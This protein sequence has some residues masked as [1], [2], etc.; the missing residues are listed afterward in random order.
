MQKDCASL[1]MPFTYNLFS[2]HFSGEHLLPR[3][4]SLMRIIDHPEQEGAQKELE[5]LSPHSTTQTCLRVKMSENASLFLRESQLESTSLMP[6]LLL[7]LSSGI[8]SPLYKWAWGRQTKLGGS[9]KLVALRGQGWLW[10][11]VLKKSS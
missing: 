8:R 11:F 6:F 9:K 10:F 1:S 7:S 4:V 3:A 5:F 2:W